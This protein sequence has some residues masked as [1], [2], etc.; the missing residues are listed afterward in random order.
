[1]TFE[2]LCVQV[3]RRKMLK[4]KELTKVLEQANTGGFQCTL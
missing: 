2:L 3:A 4:P 1:M